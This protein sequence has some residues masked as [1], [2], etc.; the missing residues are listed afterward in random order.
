MS[1]LTTRLDKIKQDLAEFSNEAKENRLKTTNNIDLLKKVKLVFAKQF[2]GL[3][4]TIGNLP[5][6]TNVV[7]EEESPAAAQT[8]IFWEWNYHDSSAKKFTREGDRYILGSNDGYSAILAYSSASSDD[9]IR[10]QVQFFDTQQ[11][12]CGGFGCMSKDDPDFIEGRY[13]SSS[14]PLFCL[15]C[16]GTWGGKALTTKGDSE[17]LQ[18]KLKRDTEKK[19]TFEINMTEGYFKVFYP[20]E[21]TLYSD[22]EIGSCTYKTNMVLIFYS[23]SSIVHS[24]EIIP[25]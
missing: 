8:Q 17:T 6:L 13:T 20:D 3:V 10:Y 2:G 11:F 1:D 4:D 25:I 24:H 12:G 19:L 23:S 16:N 9:V 22:C 15:C 21:F 7:E 14:H 5:E 18:H